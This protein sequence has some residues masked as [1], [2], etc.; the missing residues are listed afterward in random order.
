M[1]DRI[2]FGPGLLVPLV[3]ALGLLLT[4][5]LQVA[6]GPWASQVEAQETPSAKASDGRS[7]QI[8]PQLLS[9]RLPDQSHAMQDAAYHFEN[10]WFAGDK[11]NWPLAGYYLRKTQQYLELAVEIKPVRK[12]QAGAEVHLKDILDAVNNGYLAKVDQAISN[13]DAAGFKTAYRDTIAGCIACHTACERQ[14]LRVQVPTEQNTTLIDF[15]PHADT[16]Q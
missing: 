4:G 14:Y 2:Y 5:I 13:K 3:V 6:P 7:P 15:D 1:R 12:T 10:L 9:D 11:Q 16:T 8:D